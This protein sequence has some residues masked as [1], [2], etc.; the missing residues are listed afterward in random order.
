MLK[1]CKELLVGLAAQLLVKL[2]MIHGKNLGFNLVLVP[3]S[4]FLL[5]QTLGGSS[6]HSR[7]R[8]LAFH[9]EHQD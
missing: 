8:I 4:S 2:S 9:V 3:D 6:D 5:M 1:P 7:N